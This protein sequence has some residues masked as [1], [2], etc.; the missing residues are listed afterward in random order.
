MHLK[1][2]FRK[3]LSVKEGQRL[4]TNYCKINGFDNDTTQWKDP[5]HDTHWFAY[6]KRSNKRVANNWVAYHPFRDNNKY[7]VWIDLVTKEIREVL[8]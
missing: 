1:G 2:L 3:K 6:H 4:L 8:R 5:T 7:S